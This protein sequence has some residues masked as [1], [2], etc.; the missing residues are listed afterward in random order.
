M[1]LFLVVTILGIVQGLTEF[2]PVSSTGHMIL[3][4][5][6]IKGGITGNF[7]ELFL[8]I[9]QLGSIFAVIIYFW[10]MINPFVIDSK[11]RK[12]KIILWTKVGVAILP[13]VLVGLKFDDVIDAYFMDNVIIIS[14]A[15]IF[16]G[17]IFILVESYYANT[18]SEVKDID[19]ISFAKAFLVGMFQ[20]LA[21]IPG[22]SRS[23]ATIIG[24]LLLGLSRAV[25]AEFTFLLA[26]P[27]MF[28]ATL[29]K[30]R[31]SGFNFTKEEWI[32]LGL[33]TLVSFIVSYVVIR[34]FMGYIKRKSFIPF[35]IY[36]I[37]F[38]IIVLL[39]VF[40]IK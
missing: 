29:L 26:I 23:G 15:L 10:K 39:S 28:G 19:K 33:G 21:L 2:L 22:T 7:R 25:A 8:A 36:R 6:F 11:E 20:C 32:L 38:G 34:W 17:I 3:V 16:Y 35:G 27:T 13:T 18:E 24:G 5:K 14:A 30:L 4:E 31:K 40:F 37:V 1:N 12:K 9:V